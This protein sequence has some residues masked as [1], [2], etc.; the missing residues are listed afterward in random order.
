MQN[1]QHYSRFSFPGGQGDP[2]DRSPERTA[3]REA[4]E[5]LGI[6]SCDVDVWGRL[7]GI[8]DRRQ[9]SMITPVLG[10]VKNFSL[11]SLKLNHAEVCT[12]ISL[13][14]CVC[15]H[16]VCMYALCPWLVCMYGYI[17][18]VYV[19]VYVC[20]CYVRSVYISLVSMYMLCT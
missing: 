9:T 11:H 12:D 7:N 14:V 18:S 5:E 3:L 8:P 4:E 16:K 15:M 10:H 2:G 19:H 6:R 17:R 13:Y 1:F 20:T